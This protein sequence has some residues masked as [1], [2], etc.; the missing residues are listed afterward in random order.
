MHLSCYSGVGANFPSG[1]SMEQDLAIVTDL[2]NQISRHFINSL[3]F[4]D[5]EAIN[6]FK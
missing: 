2:N 1:M 4:L 3:Y 5:L 6:V